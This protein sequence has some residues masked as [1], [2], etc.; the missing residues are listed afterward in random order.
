MIKAVGH[1]DISSGNYFAGQAE[2]NSNNN[3]KHQHQPNVAPITEKSVEE[4]EKE[5]RLGGAV[6]STFNHDGLRLA[7]DLEPQCLQHEQSAE[8]GRSSCA[9][10]LKS[11][12]RSSSTS[13]SIHTPLVEP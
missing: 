12:F 6:K 13:T 10:I 2:P 4:D 11:V 8:R 3:N 7:R 5:L 9:T 1:I